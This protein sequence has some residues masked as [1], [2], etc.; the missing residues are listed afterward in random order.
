MNQ[1][2]IFIGSLI[3]IISIS[4]PLAMYLNDNPSQTRV[5]EYDGELPDQVKII[6]ESC[7]SDSSMLDGYLYYYDDHF[8]IDNYICEIVRLPEV[9]Y[10]GL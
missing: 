1:K 6:F 9:H 10:G 8:Y 7:D 5:G 2:I 3:T 4:V